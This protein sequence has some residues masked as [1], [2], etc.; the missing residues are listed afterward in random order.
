MAKTFFSLA[1]LTLLMLFQS[2]EQPFAQWRGPDRNGIFPERKLMDQWPEEGPELLWVFEGLGRGYAAPAVAGDKIFVNGEE[3]GQSFLYA[4]DLQ[5]NLLWRSPNGKEFLGEGFSSTYPGARST[6][7]V[8]GKLVY[9]TSGQGQIA[10][11]ET[12][13]GEEKWSI[14]IQDYLD[15]EVGYFGYSES[16]AVDKEHVY[17]FP[18]GEGTN[19]AA[20][21]RFTGKIAWTNSALQDTFAYGSPV[22]VDLPSLEIVM[23]TSR[24]HLFVV[25]RTNGE[26]LS[27]Y[28]LEGYE[29]DGEHCNTPVYSEGYIYFVAND[30]PG[31]GAVR[32]ELSPDGKNIKEVW[33]NPT[34]RNNFGGLVVVN[35]HLFT[36]IKGNR[37]VALDPE[38]GEVVDTLRVAT[39]SLAYADNK[40]ICYGNNGSLNLVA[41]HQNELE[42]AGEFKVMEG[43]GQHFAHP[44]L[45]NGIM[46]IRRGDGLMAYRVSEIN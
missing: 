43:S 20:L 2:C 5:G 31:Q 3:E 14:N 16:V 40:F 32:L 34:I 19:L 44:V 9:A 11:F 30:I 33:R 27:S 28:K 42:H 37:L 12:S 38:S 6:P 23:T 4:I 17:C 1:V 13:G 15:G 41:Y 39:G 7:T 24:H 10:C 18:G 22:L 45:A 8:M 21:D 35:D 46:Y 36:T 26:L 29:Y 25:D